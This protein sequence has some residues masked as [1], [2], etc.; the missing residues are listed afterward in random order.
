MVQAQAPCRGLL[1]LGL[2][3]D[4][5]IILQR[6]LTEQLPEFAKRPGTSAVS[7]RLRAALAAYGCACLRYSS[8]KTLEDKTQASFW[9][10]DCCGISGLVRPN[11]SRFWPL[12]LITVRVIQLGLATRSLLESLV[13]SWVSVF[14]G[15]R[16]LS[17]VN[18]CFQAI[19][20]GPSQA[21]LR[22]SPE[23]N[24]S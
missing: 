5:L 15:R 13:G 19:R 1:S 11:P 23:L 12:V 14:M 9:G 8:E 7:Q 3:I 16:L 10:V 6:C 2:V 17:L 21:I 20:E 24:Q 22:L 18:L 4:D